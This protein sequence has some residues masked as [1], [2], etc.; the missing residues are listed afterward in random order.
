MLGGHWR[1]ARS[2]Y[3]TCFHGGMVNVT[4]CMQRWSDPNTGCGSVPMPA[5][6]Q[7]RL[8]ACNP[9]KTACKTVGACV[10]NC[11]RNEVYPKVIP[12]AIC[13][14]FCNATNECQASTCAP[15]CNTCNACYTRCEV[16]NFGFENPCNCVNTDGPTGGY[17]PGNSYGRARGRGRRSVR[18][19]PG[20]RGRG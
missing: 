3:W 1:C 6:L 7:A 18:G 5:D 10:A 14:E 8:N 2:V 11:S 12:C 15:Y 17:G 16:G 20:G 4:T 9:C 13:N 19:G